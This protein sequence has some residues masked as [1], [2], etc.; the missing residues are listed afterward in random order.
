MKDIKKLSGDTEKIC[1]K[2][3]ENRATVKIQTS[4]GTP[5]HLCPKHR[6]KLEERIKDR[7]ED[8]FE[9]MSREEIAEQLVEGEGIL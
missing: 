9:G 3:C 6:R 8:K 1:D 5:L 4:E 2:E 7:I